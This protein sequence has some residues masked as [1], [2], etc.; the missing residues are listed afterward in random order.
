MFVCFIKGRHKVTHIKMRLRILP[1]FTIFV[2]LLIFIWMLYPS[3][4]PI[5]Y[6]DPE[7]LKN[8]LNSTLLV[9]RLIH[10]TYKTK[11]IPAKWW[12]SYENCRKI[13]PDFK[14]IF[15][16]D[17]AGLSFIKENYPWFLET[18]VGYKYPIQ[19][20]DALRYFILYHYGG[21]YM[22]LDIGCES[23]NKIQPL[24]AFD[25]VIPETKPVGY[26]N[27]MM[28][29]KPKHPFFKLLI[30]QLQRYDYNY[31]FPYLTVF[32]ST[33]PM[34]LSQVFKSYQQQQAPVFVLALSLYSDGPQKLFKHLQGSTWHGWDAELV[35]FIWTAKLYLLMIIILGIVFQVKRKRSR[36]LLYRQLPT[37]AL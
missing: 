29:S 27:D 12:Y 36:R 1:I 3:P 21:V 24:L 37:Y 8:T 19:R 18:F 35:K 9:P 26:S 7:K 30:D 25:A 28:I 6:I 31:V 14:F 11:Y 2:L 20:V 17:E 10:Q 33:G 13:Y 32:L 22:D 23:K 15:W 34:F 5:N 16:T 4:P